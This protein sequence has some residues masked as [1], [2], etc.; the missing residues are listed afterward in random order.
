MTR[1]Y[2]LAKLYVGSEGKWKGNEDLRRLL[3]GGM[4]W[5]YENMPVCRNWWHNQIGVPKKFAGILMMLRNELTP[6]ELE[7]GLRVLEKAKFGMTGQNKVWL[8]GNNLMR[9]LLINDEALVKEAAEQIKETI[10]VTDEEGIQR[11][12]SFHQH[13]A[14]LLPIVEEDL[15]ILHRYMIYPKKEEEA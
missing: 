11:D 5:W 15:N 12:W 8:A 3:H 9:G 13:G 7:G 14:Q 1:M 10:C 6:E 4:A 2:A